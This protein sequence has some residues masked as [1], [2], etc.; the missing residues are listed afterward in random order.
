MPSWSRLPLW[1]RFGAD[2]W[3]RARRALAVIGLA[4]LA[5]CQVPSQQAPVAQVPEAM[6]PVTAPSAPVGPTRVKVG[7]LLP[8][9][10]PNQALGE[11]MLAA[12]ELALFDVGEPSLELLPRDT[13]EGPAGAR[14]AAQ[15]VLAQ[16][17]EAIVGPFGAGS[18]RSV[19]PLA[20]ASNVPVIAFSTDRGVA[21][22]GT[23]LMGFM[24]DEQ[25]T[26]VVRYAATQGL[27][28]HA[29]LVPDNP[30]GA[31]V[32]AAWRQALIE[33][34]ATSV[35]VER[36]QDKSQNIEPMRRIAADGAP[37]DALLMPEGG[38]RL[39]QLAPLLTYFE[40]DTTRVRL[41]GTAQWDEPG[42][43]R[44]PQLVGAWFAGPPPQAWE[45]FS[46][47][48]QDAYAQ[49]Q[50]PARFAALAYDAVALAATQARLPAEFRFKPDALANPAGFAGANGIFRFRRD[51]VP[52]HALAVMQV[53]TDG[54]TVVDPAA[55]SFAGVGQ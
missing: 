20:A 52:E 44:V 32:L 37:F 9:S 42:I 50:P 35:R 34:G 14:A 19:A 15:A 25:V 28:R 5:A 53:G 12:A 11:A 33:S 13:G 51:G 45:T 54:Y 22:N 39:R 17:A 24:P 48:W 55:E 41:L 30:Y 7:L 2:L 31:T 10:G 46:R 36:T 1:S 21:G 3:S 18:V 4:T 43:G 49:G 23:Y 40:V 47:R 27:M 29:A 8:L 26:R 16:G 38:A 6:P